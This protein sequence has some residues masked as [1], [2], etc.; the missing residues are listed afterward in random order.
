MQVAG[1]T[2]QIN[3]RLSYSGASCQY[4]FAYEF[5]GQ[6]SFTTVSQTISSCSTGSVGLFAKTWGAPRALTSDFD[7]FDMT[8]PQS[9][10]CPSSWTCADIG[11]PQAAGSQSVNSGAWTVVGGGSDIWNPPDQFHF[12]SQSFAGDATLTARITSQAYSSDYAKAGL[13][14]RDT[15]DAGSPYYAIVEEPRGGGIIFAEWRTA[16]G[17]GSTAVQA[18]ATGVSTYLR[19]VR[20]GSTFSAY[21]SPDGSSWQPIAGSTVTIS[22]ASSAIMGGLAVTGASAGTAGHAG[23]DNVNTA[24]SALPSGGTTNAVT[25]PTLWTCTDVGGD[26]PAGTQT[27]SGGT[28]TVSAGGGGS[29]ADQFYTIWQP[30]NANGTI[31]AHVQSSTGAQAGVMIRQSSDPKA[32]YY[33]VELGNDGAAR[34]AYRHGYGGVAVWGPSVPCSAPASVEI[35]RQGVTYTAQTTCGGSGWTP[36]P[37]S[38][39]TLTM[40]DPVMAGVAVAGG[41][42]G[43]A[44]TFTLDSVGLVPSGGD[45]VVPCPTGAGWNCTDIGSPSIAGSDA[46]IDQT[47]WAV[48]G[49]PPGFRSPQTPNDVFHLTW[50]SLPASGTVSAHLNSL[51]G[52]SGAAA[53]VMLRQSSDAQSPFYAALMVGGVLSVQFRAAQGEGIVTA[54]E[55][56]SAFPTITSPYVRVERAGGIYTTSTSSDG[57]NWNPVPGTTF[58]LAMA[59]SVMAVAGGYGDV[60]VTAHFD[61]VSVSPSTGDPIVSCPVTW[62]CGDIGQPTGAGVVASDGGKSWALTVTGNGVPSDP[63]NP[64]S[65]QFTY[66]STPA[67]SGFVMARVVPFHDGNPY[68]KAGIMIR[69]GRGSGAP[70]YLVYVDASYNVDIEYRT[71]V[72]DVTHGGGSFSVGQMPVCLAVSWSGG[73]FSSAYSP[74]CN[75]WTP[76]TVTVPPISMGSPV[77]GFAADAG[78]GGGAVQHAAFGFDHITLKPWSAGPISSEL[79]SPTENATSCP[80]TQHPI[81][82]AD[83]SF[84]HDFSDLSIPGRGMPLDLTRS[85]RSPSA[86]QDGPLGFGWTDSYNMYLTTD[87]TGAVTVHEESGSSVTFDWVAGGYQA[88]ARVFATL[89]AN[90]D[91]TLTFTRTRGQEKFV[92]ATPTQSGPGQLLKEIDRNSYTTTLSYSNGLLSSVTDP[93]GRSLSFAYNSSNRISSITDPANR[94]VS[95]GYDGAGNLTSATDVGGK[96]THFTYDATHLLL[97]MTD[98]RGGV[99]TNVYDA[100]GRVTQQT[101]PMNRVTHFAYAQ[102]SDGSQTTTVTDPDGNVSTYQYQNSEVIALTRGVGTSQAATWHYAYDPATAGVTSVTDPNN[103]VWKATYDASGDLLTQTDPLNHTTTFTYDALNDLTSVADPAGVKTTLSYDGSGN[104]LSSFRPLTQSSQTAT[105]TLTYGDSAHPGEVTRITDPNGNATT[106]S[107]DLNGDLTSVTDGVG[108]TTTYAYDGIGRLTSQVSPKGNV[109]GGNPSAS[110]TTY[111]LDAYGDVTSVTDPLGHQTSYTYDP[112]GNLL[113]VRDARQ[114]LTTSSYNAD[115]E[116]TGTARADNTAWGF[117][118]DNDGNLLAQTDG[119]NRTTTYT[120]DALGRMVAQTDPLNRKTSYGYD[121]AGNLSSLVDAMGRTKSFS[122]DVANQLTGISY[123]DGTTPNVSYTYTADGQRA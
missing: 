36:I 119:L 2:E 43:Q 46:T 53:G 111:A 24:N 30:L 110:T 41:F 113:T 56:S 90:P 26:L 51:S 118:Y 84:F 58:A 76:A 106:F 80:C 97:T 89:T 5:A 98:P 95:F 65:D 37:G 42:N 100:S 74:D 12:V 27:V 93:A 88:P 3:L 23:F 109:S 123:S 54:G 14:F 99:V 50:K 71:Q 92:F 67:A 31:S 63:Y 13:I 101:D 34:V 17:V 94:S 52:G 44:A 96:T 39:V 69:D 16:Q 32:L 112:D 87:E 4:S 47:T 115:N 108:N 68:A 57:T 6:S 38:T 35:V 59:G 91:G 55:T 25:C 82:T 86:S 18:S 22:M 7:W 19:V 61:G 79:R 48:D 64:T 28:W 21:T 121:A 66:V 45:A 77:A 62:T 105:T 70:F 72:G 33:M 120:Y 15:T 40:T 10:A 20:S 29:S 1:A 114:N 102:N 81:D 9:T 117:A 104:L 11:N 103:H 83:G 49:P 73:L 85:Y 116:L 107:Y 78:P 122:Y 75:H 60:D 8:G